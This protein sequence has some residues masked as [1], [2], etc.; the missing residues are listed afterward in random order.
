MNSSVFRNTNSKSWNIN[1]VA[2]V[3][4]LGD[5]IAANNSYRQRDGE[6]SIRSSSAS[7]DVSFVGKS[8]PM[9][10]TEPS[11][12]AYHSIDSLI[13]KLQN[14]VEVTAFVWI[15]ET[16]NDILDL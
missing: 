7:E 8:F 10:H 6:L 5:S 9:T 2:L 1:S 15:C 16:S 11:G 3:L 12:S 14:G 4:S 13:E